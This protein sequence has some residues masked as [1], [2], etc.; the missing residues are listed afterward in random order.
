M[1]KLKPGKQPTGKFFVRTHMY[2]HKLAA[3]SSELQCCVLNKICLTLSREYGIFGPD[4][5]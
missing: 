1:K 2:L 5:R 3:L 4:K